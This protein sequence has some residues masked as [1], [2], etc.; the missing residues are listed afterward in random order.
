VPDEAIK[1]LED[2][3]WDW[4][5][6][7]HDLGGQIMVTP[8]DNTGYKVACWLEAHKGR[9]PPHMVIHSFNPIGAKAMGA[10]LPAAVYVPSSWTY[11]L[12][13]IETLYKDWNDV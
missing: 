7:D 12:D 6:L 2:Q 9:Q 10:A 5:F 13:T 1:L 11:S 8:G 3:D 4:L